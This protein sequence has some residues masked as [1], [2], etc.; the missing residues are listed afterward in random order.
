[1]VEPS[2]SNAATPGQEAALEQGPVL[3]VRPAVLV[4][5]ITE[6]TVVLSYPDRESCIEV[7]RSLF[8]LL[9]HFYV[10]RRVGEVVP[11]GTSGRDAIEQLRA[12]GFL[13]EPAEIIPILP[14]SAPLP[15]R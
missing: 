2:M 14:T 9:R 15:E 5:Q 10:P 4:E 12:L 7:S 13:A 6:T 11:E 3:M 8:D 1:M